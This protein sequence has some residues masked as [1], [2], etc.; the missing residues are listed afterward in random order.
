MFVLWKNFLFIQRFTFEYFYIV[1]FVYCC[2]LSTFRI[3]V[4]SSLLF[5]YLFFLLGKLREVEMRIKISRVLYSFR[6]FLVN[7]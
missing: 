7:F 4:L 6:I 3:N 1:Y 5:I 2:I